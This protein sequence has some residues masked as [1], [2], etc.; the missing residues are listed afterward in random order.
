MSHSPV[1][2][3]F[4]PIFLLIITFAAQADTNACIQDNIKGNTDPC[5]IQPCPAEADSDIIIMA[6]AAATVTETKMDSLKADS[7]QSSI[8]QTAADT[9]PA[10]EFTYAGYPRVTLT[11]NPATTKTRIK[12]LPFS[13]LT[14][15]YL[16][17]LTALH[18]YQVN[19]IWDSTT[20][21]RILEDGDYG[22]YTDKFG[23][24]W[25]TYI[26]AYFISEFLMAS[27]LSWDAATNW[28]GAMALLYQTYVE[29]LDGFGK[30]WGFSPSDMAANIVGYSFFMGHHY[31]P[32]LQNFTLK[33]SYFPPRWFGGQHRESSS[34]FIDDYSSYTY[35]LS[36][37]VYR[38]IPESWRKYWL[39]WL[40]IGVGYAARNLTYKA[41]DKKFLIGLDINPAM[42]LP[43]GGSFWNWIKQSL[44]Y[45]LLPMPT[46]ELSD[47]APPRFHLLYPFRISTGPI[48]F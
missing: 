8:A 29:V 1:R 2:F 22:L 5:H 17:A 27:G 15:T 38:L 35:L 14:G 12:P 42:L 43:D 37:N 7:A 34:S 23:H 11:G 45:V 33:T 6:M 18:I 30:N 39:P 19:T 25:G 3:L 28:G 13:L 24:I 20:H 16:G 31:W 10:S 32:F 48:H 46:L 9:V 4:F 41:G 40:N 47:T 36:A 44:N 21:F 26:N